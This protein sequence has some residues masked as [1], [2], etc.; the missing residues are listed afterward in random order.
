MPD[1]KDQPLE[2]RLEHLEQLVEKLQY[3]IERMQDRIG[4][5]TP[6]RPPLQRTNRIIKA[7]SSTPAT[8][9]PAGNRQSSKK[10][11][12][13]KQES[14]R[15]SAKP[16]PMYDL[17][18]EAWLQRIGMGLL[19]LAVA[20]ALKL[21]FDQDW[22]SPVLRV[23]TGSFVG[24]LFLAL[25]LHFHNHRRR[26]G[27][28]LV[29][30]GIATFYLTAYAAYELY[31]LVPSWIA[32]AGMLLIT[33]L[34]FPLAAR[35]DDSVLAI[36]A[37]L[38]GLA[39]PF[40]LQSSGD[41]LFVLVTYTSLILVG[42]G[43]MYW[44]R[45]W[46]SLLFVSFFGSWL[47]IFFCY[48]S[49]GFGFQSVS[50]ERWTL[51]AAVILAWVLFWM[52]PVIRGMSR[53]YNPSKW[54]AP[55][56]VK[57][58]GYFFNHPALPLSVSTPLL[59]L[60]VSMLIWNLSDSLWGWIA[61]LASSIYGF[62]YLYIR[63]KERK[64]LNHL[65]QMQGFTS[66]IFLTVGLFLL[67]N[68]HPLLIALAAEAVLIRIVAKSMQDRLFSI[69][70]HALFAFLFLWVFDRLVTI[71][72]NGMPFLNAP[73]LSE[74]IVIALGAGMSFLQNRKWLAT[75]YPLI[76]HFLV[77]VWIYR[78]PS[79][80]QSGQA[81]ITVTWGIYGVVLFLAAM[82]Y[83]NPW[84][85]RAA[86]STL[87]LVVLKLFL[88]D[89]NEV[90]PLLRILLF[91][92]FGIVFMMLSYILPSVFRKQEKAAAAKV[93]QASTEAEQEPSMQEG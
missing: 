79:A 27:Q 60:G 43:A 84:L 61:L 28:V 80:L 65:A 42:A 5:S 68:G 40:I 75:A 89:L 23:M 2:E 19:F 87:A 18:G 58:V 8:S 50:Q 81:V 91:L 54:P 55:P 77:L 64:D 45:G 73:A 93:S 52:M 86:F 14:A 69:V 70:S 1:N 74:L 51:Q 39:T 83:G 63:G 85:R 56:P 47:V 92:G 90:E 20:F 30:G 33:V 13:A 4:S 57:A 78:E 71:P 6:S 3:T 44:F 32:F 11:A 66:S 41:Y 17:N 10:A 88:I 72:S 76:A 37:T 24:L 46:R 34:S 16:R 9:Q 22:F 25:G 49:F 35:R 36:L 31:E 62:L 12:E 7:A 48:F 53:A 59:T 26:F 82:R 21:S 15:G 67:Y 38:G 29:G